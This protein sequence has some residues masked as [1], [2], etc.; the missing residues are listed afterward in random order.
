MKR[1]RTVLFAGVLCSVGLCVG[2]ATVASAAVTTV[3]VDGVNGSGTSC[4]RSLPCMTITQGLAAALAAGPGSEVSVLTEANYGPFTI[5]NQSVTIKGHHLFNVNTTTGSAVTV[6]ISATDTVVLDGVDL[7]GPHVGGS[8]KGIYFT[9]SG[10]LTVRNSTIQGFGYNI[11]QAGG[12]LNVEG[13]KISAFTSSAAAVGLWITNGDA[14]I[15]NT[16]F[17]MRGPSWGIDA[18]TGANV[19]VSGRSSVFSGGDA[20][21]DPNSYGVYAHINA[22][23]DLVDT[24]IRMLATAIRSTTSNAVKVT[25]QRVHFA[26]NT[27]ALSSLFGGQICSFGDNTFVQNGTNGSFNCLVPPVIM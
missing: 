15:V 13:S 4:T 24:K 21:P 20:V 3:Y 9:G 7:R 11:H 5:T 1:Y 14:D 12:C 27:V 19:N 22:Q 23:V 10:V 18:D 17:R 26:R 6:T 2:A 16:K 25:A 8:V